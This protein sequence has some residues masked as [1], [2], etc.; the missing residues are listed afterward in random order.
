MSSASASGHVAANGTAK[1][2]MPRSEFP[3]VPKSVRLF[4]VTDGTCLPAA[5]QAAACMATQS[6]CLT[7]GRQMLTWV[8]LGAGVLMLS[9]WLGLLEPLFR[10]ITNLGTQPGE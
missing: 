1:K 8:A 6:R 5:G 7:V 2:A 10:I 3:P 9:N 4:S